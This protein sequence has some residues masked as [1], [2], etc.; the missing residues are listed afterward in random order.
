VKPAAFH[1]ENLYSGWKE[2]YQPKNGYG[3]CA[4]VQIE[5]S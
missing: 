3:A 2:W 5:G 1:L 4:K